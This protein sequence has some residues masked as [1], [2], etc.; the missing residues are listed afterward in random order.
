MNDHRI[1]N[2]TAMDEKL[3][4]DHNLRMTDKEAEAVIERFREEEEA[5][6]QEMEARATMPT[7]KDLAEGLNVSAERVENLLNKVRQESLEPS[8]QAEIISHQAAKEEV[9]KSN[10]TAL[11]I[12]GVIMLCI[13]MGFFAVLLFVPA[14]VQINPPSATSAPA[15]ES[16]PVIADDV[17]ETPTAPEPSTN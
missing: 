2:S 4:E 1:I 8:P 13:L 17:G 12:G 11:I 15:V 16:G 5:N 7:V 10:R 6:R 9:A 14:Q 3:R